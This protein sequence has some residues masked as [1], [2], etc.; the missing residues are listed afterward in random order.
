[1]RLCFWNLKY[2]QHVNLKKVSKLTILKVSGKSTQV[3]VLRSFCIFKLLV[4]L[5]V[6]NC[7]LNLETATSSFPV[8]TTQLSKPVL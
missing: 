2:T 4:Q 7:M 6:D 3:D 5:C 1:M 8:Q